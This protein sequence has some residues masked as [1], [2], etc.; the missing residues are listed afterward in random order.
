[1]LKS[2]FK[3]NKAQPKARNLINKCNTIAIEVR[4]AKSFQTSVNHISHNENRK[5]K[6]N[7]TKK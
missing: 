2:N 5:L 4:V 1:M 3:P 7:V 6:T